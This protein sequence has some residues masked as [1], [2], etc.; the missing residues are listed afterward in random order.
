MLECRVTCDREDNNVN[1][2]KARLNIT[3][4]CDGCND[5]CQTVEDLDAQK[6]SHLVKGD[7]VMVPVPDEPCLTWTG[8]RSMRS[9]CTPS[10]LSNTAM[11]N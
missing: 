10:L 6:N 5:E 9:V 11:A 3:F 8:R 1:A 2:D 4:S 7:K